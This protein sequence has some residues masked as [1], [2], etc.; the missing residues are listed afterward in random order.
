[1]YSSFR[2]QGPRARSPPQRDNPNRVSLAL[3]TDPNA[4]LQAISEFDERGRDPFLRKYGFGKADRHRYFLE[5]NGQRYDSKAIAGVAVGKQHPERGPLKADEFHGGEPVK[6][7][8]EELGFKVAA[9][10]LET[11]RARWD[12]GGSWTDKQAEWRV[13]RDED[14]P[15]LL[16]IMRRFQE[17]EIN[18]SEFRFEMDRFGKRTKLAGFGGIAGQMFF[19]LLVKAAPEP[20][21]ADALRAALPAP[22]DDAACG[23]TFERFLSFVE[24][25]GE[26]AKAGG[27]TAPALGYVPYFLSFFW[28]AQDIDRWPIYYPASRNTLIRY[29][30]FSDKGP[31]PERYLQFR[32]RMDQLRTDFGGDTWDIE[33]FLWTLNSEATAATKPAAPETDGLTPLPDTPEV[34]DLYETLQLSDLFFPDELVTSLV[35]SLMT[36]PFVLLRTRITMSSGAAGNR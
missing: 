25:A 19:N 8:L 7:K 27:G 4:V 10:G 23:V 18:A 33:T 28:E 31:L 21:V 11:L 24:S 35:L 5:H 14:V 1:L 13:A 34:A 36:K 2:E 22:A 30:L 12:A 16:G 6:R 9:P 3:L 32:D 20:E 17:G 29:G 15:E 26:L